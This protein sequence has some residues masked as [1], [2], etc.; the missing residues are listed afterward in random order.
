MDVGCRMLDV[1]LRKS[2]LNAK[3]L[4]WIEKLKIRNRNPGN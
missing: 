2:L 1:G 4:C 3:V